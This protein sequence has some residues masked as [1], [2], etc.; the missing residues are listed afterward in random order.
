MRRGKEAGLALSLVLLVAVAMLAVPS[1]AGAKTKTF[2]S[3]PINAPIPN[4]APTGV[5]APINVGKKGKLKD[6]NVGVRIS[7]A[8]VDQ[9][10]VYLFK[11]QKY[12]NLATKV[13]T[14]GNHFGSGPADCNGVFTVF[15]GAA[16]TFI[17]TGRAPFNGAYRPQQ[18]LGLFDGDQIKGEWR[19]FVYDDSGG[20]S[21]LINCW[22]LGLNYKKKK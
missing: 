10:H 18:S 16:P 12:I 6:A 17:Q 22:T 13:G 9:L 11:G 14:M 4:N 20:T 8:R 3:G 7:H 2:V 15:D 21:G 19:L 1:V 5:F